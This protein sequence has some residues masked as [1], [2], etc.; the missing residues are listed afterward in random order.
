[1]QEIINVPTLNVGERMYVSKKCVVV[2]GTNSKPTRIFNLNGKLLG[3][4]SETKKER[5][6]AKNIFFGEKAFIMLNYGECYVKDYDGNIIQTYKTGGKYIIREFRFLLQY[7]KSNFFKNFRERKVVS[8]L[9]NFATDFEEIQ[10]GTTIWI[11]L[12]YLIVKTKKSELK[13]YNTFSH[14]LL[15]TIPKANFNKAKSLRKILEI[16]CH[17]CGIHRNMMIREK[18][19]WKIV[20]QDGDTV[21]ENIS[22]ELLDI[23]MTRPKESNEVFEYNGMQIK[24][25]ECVYR[26][27]NVW[28]VKQKDEKTFRFYSQERKIIKVASTYEGRFIEFF[29]NEKWI[30]IET[31]E[32]STLSWQIFDY[33]GKLLYKDIYRIVKRKQMLFVEGVDNEKSETKNLWLFSLKGELKAIFEGYG[34]E[35]FDDEYNW[36]RVYRDLESFEIYDYNGKKALDTIFHDE[37]DI[38]FDDIIIHENPENGEYIEYDLKTGKVYILKCQKIKVIDEFD[39][40]IIIIVQNGHCGVF[41]YSEEDKQSTEFFRFE[42]LIPIKYDKITGNGHYFYAKYQVTDYYGKQSVFEDIY[43]MDGNLILKVKL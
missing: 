22:D 41:E 15:G 39:S 25:G 16:N 18:N 14:K 24:E 38:M 21:V 4:V 11:S 20:T 9:V 26:Y 6:L 7:E 2:F 37:K 42:Q 1:M 17:W 28:V 32:D 40:L 19:G 34:F 36:V 10:K 33:D 8:E 31:L 3:E 12:H 13:I 35:F 30:A 43:D 29:E 5:D 27:N 23:I